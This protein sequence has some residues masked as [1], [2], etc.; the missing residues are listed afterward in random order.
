MKRNLTIITLLITAIL[1]VV[2]LAPSCG[3]SKSGL[4]LLL[5]DDPID[6]IKGLWVKITAID[7][8]GDGAPISLTINP[9][10]PQPVNLL[11]LQNGLFAELV[12]G[13]DNANKLPPGQYG[14][15][16]ITIESAAITF[17]DDPSEVPTPADVPPD[18]FNVSGPITIAEDSITEVYFIFHASN[19]LHQTGNGKWIIH[20][21]IKLMEK[22][23]SG[24]ISGAVTP[25]PSVNTETGEDVEVKLFAD[26]GT[27]NESWTQAASDG[28]FK[29]IPIREGTHAVKA[30][31]V[32]LKDVDGDGVKD[33][34]DCKEQAYGDVVVTAE[35]DIAIGTITLAPDAPACQ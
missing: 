8:Y 11:K 14:N 10:L 35:Q 13:S 25:I 1:A 18:K 19:S 23:V 22:N 7:V 26:K 27:D 30:Q 16:K 2:F 12:D 32:T 29:L 6:S 34:T 17:T 3:Q 31:W 33:I 5:V 24:S 15:M 20:P 4:S 21:S 28:T 9:D